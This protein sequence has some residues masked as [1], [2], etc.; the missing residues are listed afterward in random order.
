MRVVDTLVL[1]LLAIAA[2]AFVL[3]V[4]WLGER[5]DL[6]AL[7]SLAVGGLGLRAGTEALRPREEP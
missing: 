5:H 4:L 6:A 3:G 2:L 7:V 1:V